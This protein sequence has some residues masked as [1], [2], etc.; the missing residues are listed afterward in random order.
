MDI[1]ATDHRSEHAVITA[2]L[3]HAAPLG[4][5]S[6]FRAHIVI[7]YLDAAGYEITPKAESPVLGT[8]AMLTPEGERIVQAIAAGDFTGI[9]DA[10]FEAF[11]SIRGK[12]VRGDEISVKL[13]ALTEGYMSRDAAVA[14]FGK[15]PNWE[16]VEHRN[17]AARQR[18]DEAGLLAPV[19]LTFPDGER[20]T[21]AEITEL[22]IDL[23]DG[24]IAADDQPPAPLPGFRGWQEMAKRT[25]AERLRAAPWSPGDLLLES[26][27]I[28]EADHGTGVRVT[29]FMREP[30]DDA[31]RS[32]RVFERFVTARDIPNRRPITATEMERLGQ[33]IAYELA[34]DVNR[35]RKEV[36]QALDLFKRAAEVIGEGEAR[37]LSGLHHVTRDAA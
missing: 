9:S 13:R 12:V 5:S 26:H 20:V 31:R 11:Q 10:D 6:P 22:A 23:T 18:A 4:I 14:V 21:G 3:D 34:M 15:P 28:K 8:V 7:E 35:A 36:Q 29:V 32:T 2:A 37:R 16:E 30:G 24:A 27:T 25:A 1:K 19:T 17:A 33:S